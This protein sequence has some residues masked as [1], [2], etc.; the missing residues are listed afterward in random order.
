MVRDRRMPGGIAPR[1][2][3]P[4]DGRFTFDEVTPGELDLSV[5]A[6]G[7]AAGGI[8]DVKATAGSTTTVEVALDRGGMLK[9]RVTSA[10]QPVSDVV[11]NVSMQGAMTRNMRPPTQIRTDASGEYTVD[12]L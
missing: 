9:G 12:G 1:K 4:D 6:K 11:V 3:T 8:V 10:G 7:Y 2:F 5:Q